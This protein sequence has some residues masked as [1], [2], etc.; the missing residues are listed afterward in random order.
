MAEYTHL[1]NISAQG[2]ISSSAQG[3][4]IGSFSTLP[5]ASEINKGQ[6]VL[7]TG[8][9]GTYIKGKYYV[10]DGSSWTVSDASPSSVTVDSA[11]SSTSTNP[12]QNKVVNS[13]L[14]SV[15]SSISSMNSNISSMNS[16]LSG[17]QDKLTVGANLDS[18]PTSGSS[19]PVT[20]GGVYSVIN[21]KQDA[22]TV[23]SSEPTSSDGSN[24]QLWAVYE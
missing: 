13:A 1:N 19:N 12:V 21:G 23:S 11:L 20:S 2:S 24:G 18:T 22:I 6:I 8:E 9:S 10:S 4:L 16:T 7:Y 3:K 5:A 17:K 14:S 15:N